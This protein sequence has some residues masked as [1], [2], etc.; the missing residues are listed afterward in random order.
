MYDGLSLIY[1][2]ETGFF[3]NPFINIRKIALDGAISVEAEYVDKVDD[4]FI[5]KINGFLL[6]GTPLFLT[7][8]TDKLTYHR[9]YVTNNARHRHSIVLWGMNFDEGLAY[10]TDSFI[11][12]YTGRID[13]YSGPTQLSDIRNCAYGY[14]LFNVKQ[15]AAV[16]RDEVLKRA[17]NSI[18]GF[19]NKAKDENGKYYGHT[20]VMKYVESLNSINKMDDSL[21]LKAC[22]DTHYTIK[23]MIKHIFEYSESL[24]TENLNEE[25]NDREIIIQE[26]KALK[27]GWD[28]M[29]LL[30]LLSGKRKDK[31]RISTIIEDCKNLIYKQET[32][33][34]GIYESIGKIVV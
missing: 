12:D 24:V 1:D 26:L 2:T 17:L 32:V 23:I 30:F 19:L 10:V 4:E 6:N 14:A 9:A 20:S 34:K 25:N 13:M 11:M 22:I 27:D 5:K 8:F 7:V 33:F 28:K 31:G 16:P 29:A 15:G 3:G 21:F 18:N